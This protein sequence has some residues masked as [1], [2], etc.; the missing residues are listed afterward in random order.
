MLLT[1]AVDEHKQQRG[2]LDGSVD[3]VR[4]A[5][6][7]EVPRQHGTSHQGFNLDLKENA[8]TEG[9]LRAALDSAV[10]RIASLEEQMEA[11]RERMSDL[12]RSTREL[13]EREEL[14]EFPEAG[15]DSPV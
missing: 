7:R 6:G 11:L 15:G 5:L 2:R 8:V 1:I 13:E 12:E 4:S 10:E 9:T 3:E 14:L